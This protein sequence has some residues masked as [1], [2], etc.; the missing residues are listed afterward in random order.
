M[1]IEQ[2]VAI[3]KPDGMIR[4]IS[5]IQKYYRD[6]RLGIVKQTFGCFT[7]DLATKFY[8]E[9]E[10][11]SFFAELIEHMTS[12]PCCFMILQGE[13]AVQ[14]VRNIN[15]KTDPFEAEA[16]SIRHD[17]RNEE[18]GGPRNIVH[19]SDSEASAHRE[20]ALISFLFDDRGE[21]FG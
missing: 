8:A 3:I 16:G 15:G 18:S 19:G 6:E 7:P 10:G 11:K 4:S 9:H 17:F 21:R 2:T 20:I 14:K 13:D 12:G 1:A 5:E